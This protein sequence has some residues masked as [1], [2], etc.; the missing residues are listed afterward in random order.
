MATKSEFA[1]GPAAMTDGYSMNGSQ[2]N[3]VVLNP[4]GSLSGGKRFSVSGPV[5]GRSSPRPANAPTRTSGPS[6][7]NQRRG[8]TT[9]SCY[10]GDAGA[11]IR[12]SGWTVRRARGRCWAS[13]RSPPGIRR[14]AVRSPENLPYKKCAERGGDAHIPEASDVRNPPA[15]P[16]G[17]CPAGLRRPGGPGPGRRQGDL[18][19][20]PRARPNVEPGRK[21]RGSGRELREGL[22]PR[23]NGLRPQQYQHGRDSRSPGRL[24]PADGRLRQGRVI[25]PAGPDRLRGSARRQARPAHGRGPHEPG[26]PPPGAGPVRQGRTPPP[27]GPGPPP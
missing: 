17:R 23:P 7:R 25:L 6:T 5:S 21:V 20:R 13:L 24:L 14:P 8:V 11:D 3:N 19:G 4:A 12:Y 22:C 18:A 2:A 10:R 1:V 26:Q 16:S 15:R 27:P 9:G